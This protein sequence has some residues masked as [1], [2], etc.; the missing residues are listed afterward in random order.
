[1]DRNT[2]VAMKTGGKKRCPL[3][4]DLLQNIPVP[5]EIHIVN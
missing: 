2:V 4:I 5:D 3:Q 1:M